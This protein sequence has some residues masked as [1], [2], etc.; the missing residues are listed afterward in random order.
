[1][2]R[3]TPGQFDEHLTDLASTTYA[4]AR[5]M[6]AYP[7][8]AATIETMRGLRELITNIDAYPRFGLAWDHTGGV[9]IMV[10]TAYRGK[11]LLRATIYND[12]ACTMWRDSETDPWATRTTLPKLTAALH[13]LAP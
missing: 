9:R 2:D 11:P 7:M 5:N 4:E 6:G 10:D 1:M 12:G 8:N 13:S 3:M